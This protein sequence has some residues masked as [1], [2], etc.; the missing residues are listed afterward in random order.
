MKIRDVRCTY[1]EYPYSQ[2][3][4]PSWAPERE[5][6]KSFVNVFEV[7]TDEGIVGYGSSSGHGAGSQRLGAA[8]T[9]DQLV[10]PFLVGK[11]PFLVEQHAI[12]LRRASLLGFR[13]WG[14]EQALWDIIG[15]ACGQPVYRLWGAFNDRLLAYASFGE[16]RSAEQR[17]EDVLRLR[18]EGFKAVK[19]RLHH[20][21]PSED[22]RVVEKVV[23][24]VNGT[25]EIMV[26]ANQG[27]GH[28]SSL[29][30]PVWTFDVALRMARELGAMG[31]KWL[32]EP[33][34]R[35]DYAALGKLADAV[36]IP[37]ATG[38]FN[39][40]INEF[41]L[42]LEAGIDI[43]QPDVALSEGAFQVRKIAALAE[44]KGRICTPHTWGSAIGF[45]ANLHM[46]AS[47]PNSRYI[48]F[49]YDPPT[50]PVESWQRLIRERIAIDA[51]GCI[52]VPG[53]PGLGVSPD[54]ELIARYGTSLPDS[55]RI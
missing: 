47:T 23:L 22:L 25:M 27:G 36:D 10:K 40:G 30:H 55:A 35:F 11:D 6:S 5:E 41:N 20:M 2:V 39:Q 18:S 37:I 51:D 7:T 16:V 31:I 1:V 4:R 48:E 52:K 34:P 19:L 42:I 53:A 29:A 49:P 33:L 46:A 8:V 9:V 13:V 15:K 32:E 44:A 3:F 24:A 43:I 21:D 54:L 50:F 14:V 45:A 28:S 38:E 12:P 26:D 17:V